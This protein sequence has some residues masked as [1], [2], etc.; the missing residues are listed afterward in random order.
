MAKG[1][2]GC[3]GAMRPQGFARA[4]AKGTHRSQERAR[5]RSGTQPPLH[6]ASCKATWMPWGCAG[7][8]KGVCGGVTLQGALDLLHLA[9]KEK[10]VFASIAPPFPWELV[11]PQPY[12][13]PVPTIPPHARRSVPSPTEHLK[14]GTLWLP[15]QHTPPQKIF[16]LVDES[17]SVVPVQNRRTSAMAV[18]K[19][20]IPVG[21]KAAP[22]AVSSPH[23]GKVCEGGLTPSWCASALHPPSFLTRLAQSSRGQTLLTCGGHGCCGTEGYRVA[24]Y[25]PCVMCVA[26]GGRGKGRVCTPAAPGTP[27]NSQH[28]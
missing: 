7:L 28:Q 4:G 13:Q 8:G 24:P 12:L 16:Y 26:D 9:E 10:N 25:T 14:Q 17:T 22:R 6:G 27:T 20:I 11:T 5:G 15:Q 2:P 21:N 19:S 18:G 23:P 1:C 3:L